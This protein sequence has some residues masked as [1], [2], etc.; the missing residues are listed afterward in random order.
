[1]IRIVGTTHLHQPVEPGFLVPPDIEREQKDHYRSL[2]DSFLAGTN[3][4]FI[5][6]EF[7]H[8]EET[9]ASLYRGCHVYVN[10]DMP[11]E[12]RIERDMPT[13]IR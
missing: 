5:G 1:M 9:F 8:G 10:I 13:G 4:W 2:I 12:L 11:L 6:E 7:R 3:G